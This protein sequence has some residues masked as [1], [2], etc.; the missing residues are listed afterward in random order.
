MSKIQRI[1]NIIENNTKLMLPVEYDRAL[2]G[3]HYTTNHMTPV[4]TY[5]ALIEAHMDYHKETEEASLKYVEDNIITNP[6]FIIVDD[7]GV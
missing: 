3:I 2:I 6:A 4:Y 7:T 5:L 1:R